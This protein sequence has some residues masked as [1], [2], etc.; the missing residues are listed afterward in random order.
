VIVTRFLNVLIR[1]ILILEL[2]QDADAAD[3]RYYQGII[4]DALNR[5]VS[6]PQRQTFILD[7]ASDIPSQS[8]CGN[9]SLMRCAP[10]P[11][12]YHKNPALAQQYAAEASSPTHPHPTCQQACQI[13]T[14]LITHILNNPTS[15]SKQNL[16]DILQNFNNPKDDE[17]VAGGHVTPALRDTLGRYKDLTSFLQTKE[18]DIKSSGYV[19]HTL[20]AALWAFFTTETFKE[21][22]LKVVNLGD[23]ADTVGAVYGGL[24]GAWYGVEALPEE[25]MRGVQAKGMLDGVVEGVV[26]LVERGGYM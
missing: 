13:Y 14:H 9:G 21:G 7:P 23:D 3:L 12:V 19:V 4:D 11:L 5:E 17:P 10:I 2:S 1:V 15:S 25:W 24:A 6:R 16:W 20:E 8:S 26:G 18:E 22:A